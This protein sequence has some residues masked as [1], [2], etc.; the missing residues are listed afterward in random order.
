[1]TYAEAGELM[2][3]SGGAIRKRLDGF[4]KR[5]RHRLAWLETE[6]TE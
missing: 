5:A 1:M 2:G 4:R 3:L 6:R